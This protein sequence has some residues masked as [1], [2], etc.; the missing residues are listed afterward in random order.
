MKFVQA[1]SALILSRP[2]SSFTASSRLHHRTMM[3]PSFAVSE[4]TRESLLQCPKIT[5]HDG[6]LHPCIGFGTYKVGFMPASA[7][8]VAAVGSAMS[9]PEKSTQESILD[10]LDCG[11]RFFECAEF[12]GNEVDIGKAIATSGIKREDLFLCSKVWTSTI[13]K[14]PHAVREQLEKTLSD[15]GTDYVDLYCTC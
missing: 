3:K 2:V 8:S 4:N 5:L 7:S 9:K 1:F 11:Y 14:G 6:T 12:Y 10:A 15:L 13:D